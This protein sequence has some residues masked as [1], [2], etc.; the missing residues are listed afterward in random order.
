MKKLIILSIFVILAVILSAQELQHEAIAIN[1]EVPVRVFKVGK[2]IDNLTIDDFQ[3]YEEGVE[4]KIDAV[5]LIKKTT[6]E[7]EE[8]ELEKEEAVSYTHL[9]L[10]TTPYV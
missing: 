10:P 9:T 6:I 3:L 1:I 4:Q 5:Y 2:F 8:S 7:R